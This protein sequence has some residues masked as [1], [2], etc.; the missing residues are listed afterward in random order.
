MMNTDLLINRMLGLNGKGNIG[1]KHGVR[2][3]INDTNL[4]LN[5]L[6]FSSIK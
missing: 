5:Y 2:G 3:V 6:N 1:I 4:R